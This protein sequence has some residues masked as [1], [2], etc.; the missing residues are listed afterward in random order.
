ME[1]ILRGVSVLD[2]STGV[3]GP[4]CTK[5]LADQGAEVIKVELPEGDPARLM[6]PFLDGKDS[7]ETSAHFLYLNTN[8]KGVTLDL[9]ASSGQAVL[10]RLVARADICVENY[11]PAES[12]RLGITYERFASAN[13]R[14]ILTWFYLEEM[15]CRDI[16]E[17]LSIPTGTVKSRL[18]HA[19][20]AL[21][22]CLEEE[23]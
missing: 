5:M 15:S 4:F 21:R 8:K 1:E 11:P 9:S 14:L 17:A 10:D 2:L 3:S 13:Q 6:G 23:R 22:G 18:H 12:R 20:T 16:A 7:D 19:R